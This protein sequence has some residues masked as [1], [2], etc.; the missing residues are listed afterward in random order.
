M[1]SLSSGR[2]YICLCCHM[3]RTLSIV[4]YIIQ[5][6]DTGY[7]RSPL[8]DALRLILV[9]NNPLQHNNIA[10]NLGLCLCDFLKFLGEALDFGE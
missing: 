1:S 8:S 2:G 6:V 5:L 7:H 10:R 9:E 4:G 3:E